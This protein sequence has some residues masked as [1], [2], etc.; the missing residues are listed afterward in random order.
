[1]AKMKAE[2]GKKKTEATE[3]AGTK[4]H[5]TA[6]QCVMVHQTAFLEAYELCGTITGAADAANVARRQH[7][8]WIQKDPTYFERF[9]EAGGRYVDRLVAAA[10]R[11]GVGVEIPVF[12]RAGA[13]IGHKF[14]ASDSLLAMLIKRNDRSYSERFTQEISVSRTSTMRK[15][16][17]NSLVLKKVVI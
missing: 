15:R 3:S 8:E 6:R 14:E 9:E 4:P 2:A 1:M 16:C 13:V 10:V 5:K 11:R 17:S 7:F 12:D